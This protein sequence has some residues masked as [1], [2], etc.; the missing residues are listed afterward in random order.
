MRGIEELLDPVPP[1]D[2]AFRLRPPEPGDIGWV[3]ARH[4]AVYAAEDGFDLRFEALVAEIAGAFVAHLDTERERCW[5]A[6]QAGAPVGSVFLVKDTDSV[7]KLRLLL[8]EPAARGLGIG[9]LLVEECIDFA[10]AAGY[11]KITLWTQS[12]LVAARRIYAA[13]GF[14]LVETEP[15]HSFGRDLVGE[16]WERAL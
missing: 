12:I 1:E 11:R 13:A 9:R 5:I 3:V 15:H 10:R 6:E 7:A 8:V 2:E 14:R 16:Y 4:G